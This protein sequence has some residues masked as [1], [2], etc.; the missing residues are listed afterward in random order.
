MKGVRVEYKIYYISML[1]GTLLKTKWVW[2][3]SH[4]D[5]TS[6]SGNFAAKFNF[7]L[8]ST[9]LL[10]CILLFR[11]NLLMIITTW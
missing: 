5:A 7:T 1:W 6:V 9:R 3:L 8:H 10:Y 11:S 2:K 4:I